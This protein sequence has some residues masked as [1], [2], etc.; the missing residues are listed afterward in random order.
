MSQLNTI[1]GGGTQGTT[2]S[3][4]ANNQ[5]NVSTISSNSLQSGSPTSILNSSS[6]VSLAQTPLATV[7]LGTPTTTSTLATTTAGPKH[8]VNGVLLGISGVLILIALISF[9]VI[10][11]SSN[12][13]TDS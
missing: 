12:N 11:Q 5:S 1:N 9:A 4:Q 7:N 10:F 8:H 2:A 3:P 13:T 6:G